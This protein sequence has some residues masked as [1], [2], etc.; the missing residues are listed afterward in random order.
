MARIATAA[1]SVVGVGCIALTV[2]GSPASAVTP[3]PVCG[4]TTCTVTFSTAGTG[5][6]WVVP[7]GV[8]SESITLYGAIGGSTNI[9]LG[10]DGAK[11]TGT[12]ALSPGTSVTVPDPR[13]GLSSES[14]AT[15]SELTAPLSEWQ[16]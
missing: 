14:A 15:V 1:L 7:A 8:M 3:T 16:G 2:M 13:C 12:L 11:V 4:G 9:V 6:T 10:G 5:Q